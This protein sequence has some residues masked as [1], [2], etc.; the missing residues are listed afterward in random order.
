[1]LPLAQHF[2]RDYHGQTTIHPLGLL[3]VLAMGFVMLSVRRK[4]A[5]WPVIV[6]VCRSSARIVCL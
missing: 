3:M 4:Y 5:L 6:I 2:V 1:M